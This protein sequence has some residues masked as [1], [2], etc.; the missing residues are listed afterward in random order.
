MAS[1]GSDNVYHYTDKAG[2]EGIMKEQ[3]LRA[4]TDTMNDA[5]FG[6]GAY[7]TEKSPLTPTRIIKENIFDGMTVPNSR[8]DYVLEVPKS[9]LLEI[10]IIKVDTP[11]A[12]HLVPGAGGVDLR[13][14]PFNV[15][16]RKS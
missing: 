4:S 9:H 2:A 7:F 1:G 14:I 3:R 16:K 8:I 5:V 15:I 11:R 12:V 10:G 6:T 13:G